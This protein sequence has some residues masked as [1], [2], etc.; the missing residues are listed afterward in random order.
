MFLTIASLLLLAQSSTPANP[1]PAPAKEK[2][3]CRG[4]QDTGSR[5]AKKI[6]HTKAEWAQ[7]AEQQRVAVEKL[8]DRSRVTQR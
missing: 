5:F 3:I 7:I 4:D 1:V 2:K 8:E 6:C